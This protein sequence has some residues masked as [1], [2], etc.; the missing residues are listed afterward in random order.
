M[1]SW[2]GTEEN[3]RVTLLCDPKISGVGKVNE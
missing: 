2:F 1:V 3:R